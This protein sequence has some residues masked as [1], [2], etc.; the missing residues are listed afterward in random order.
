MRY[1]AYMKPIKLAV[2]ILVCCFLFSC[3][4]DYPSRS[5]YYTKCYFLGEKSFTF[6]GELSYNDGTSPQEQLCLSIVVRPYAYYST[7]EWD[8]YDGW[9]IPGIIISKNRFRIEIDT[10]ANGIIIDK[11]ADV[12]LGF[13]FNGSS[14]SESP[15][16]RE[17]SSRD[18]NREYYGHY[19]CSYKFVAEP[20]DKSGKEIDEGRGEF[21][22]YKN[23]YYYDLNYSKPGWYKVI[24]GYHSEFKNDPFKNDPNFSSTTNNYFTAE[25]I[26]W[27][28]YH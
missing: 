19:Y 25:N 8:S 2:L 20:I 22:Y 6:E 14:W 18:S 4:E 26:E 15:H 3:P 17:L 24:S 21:G 9:E 12:R 5:T 13:Y 11:D 10:E 27:R 23:T 1:I 28:L 16:Y 7:A